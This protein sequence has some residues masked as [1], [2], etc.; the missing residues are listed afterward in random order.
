MPGTSDADLRPVTVTVSK[1]PGAG[2]GERQLHGIAGWASALRQRNK[3]GDRRLATG[4]PTVEI[5]NREAVGAERLQGA[6]DTR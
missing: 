2:I 5:D 3:Q 4:H 6:C 1:W